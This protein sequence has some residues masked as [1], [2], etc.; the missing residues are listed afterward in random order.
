MRS[1][2]IAWLLTLFIVLLGLGL[3]L[4]NEC[5]Y[6]GA[7][8]SVYRSCDCAGYEW[9]L[10]DRTEADGPR[11]TICIGVIQSTECYQYLNGPVEEC[12]FA[13]RV[14]VKTDKQEY[15][16]GEDIEIVIINNLNNPIRYNGF[17]SMHLCQQ[18]G[19][20]WI[21]EMKECYHETVVIESGTSVETITQV[22]T[23]AATRYKFRF[24]YQTMTGNTLYTIHSNDFTVRPE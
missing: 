21:C 5:A 3:V 13:T 4:I 2:N 16:V 23:L 18:I 8:G 7:M 24:E 11:K 12:D 17:C 14:T 6:G 20:E 15:V 10:Y 1:N 22:N 9:E 19:E